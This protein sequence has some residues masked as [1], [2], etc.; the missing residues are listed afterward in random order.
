VGL[1]LLLESPAVRATL[2]MVAH[3]N[4]PAHRPLRPASEGRF[5]SPL[6]PCQ[7]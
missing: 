4:T 5:V 2:L 6:A 3:L 7:P 1:E